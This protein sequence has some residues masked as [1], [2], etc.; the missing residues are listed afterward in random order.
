MTKSPAV[1]SDG[2][3]AFGV[4]FLPFGPPKLPNP[5]L[6]SNQ[7]RY[8]PLGRTATPSM[9]SWPAVVM[10]MSVVAQRHWTKVLK[11][12][13]R[14]AGGG[15]HAVYSGAWAPTAPNVV[16]TIQGI[17]GADHPLA[18]ALHSETKNVYV[19]QIKLSRE[20]HNVSYKTTPS[21][22]FP[23]IIPEFKLQRRYDIAITV[24]T[25]KPACYATCSFF[26]STQPSTQPHFKFSMHLS[27]A[28]G[29]RCTVAR[30][31]R[32]FV[33]P[34]RPPDLAMVL[35]RGTCK[36]RNELTDGLTLI[37]ASACNVNTGHSLGEGG[38]PGDLLRG[39]G[40]S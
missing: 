39:R 33:Q 21:S 13:V 4:V 36:D 14:T 35:R 28:A 2:L 30:P 16:G 15:L 24:T 17:S 18:A 11:H 32:A 5:T 6:T 9:S 8:W 3:A 40:I 25:Q 19:Y 34:C 26:V 27:P 7:P 23:I 20:H 12:A 10:E 31:R 38:P 37:W 29:E 22:R 1:K